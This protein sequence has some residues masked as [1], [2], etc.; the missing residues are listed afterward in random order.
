MASPTSQTGGLG[1][2]LAGEATVFGAMKAYEAAGRPPQV[3]IGTFDLGADALAGLASGDLAFAIDQQE[4]LQG[5]M[6]VLT[7]TIYLTTGNLMAPKV[8]PTGPA[9]I[10]EVPPSEQV[11]RQ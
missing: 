9:F 8:Y 6:S 2:L 1:V 10:T 5:Y 7:A 4:W 11:I 3:S